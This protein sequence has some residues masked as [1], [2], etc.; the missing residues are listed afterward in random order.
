[1]I[2]RSSSVIIKRI[3]AAQTRKGGKAAM[4]AAPGQVQ[5]SESVHK[6][7]TYNGV[8]WHRGAISKRFDGKEEPGK[9]SSMV[10]RSFINVHGFRSISFSRIHLQRMPQK[11]Q[12]LLPWLPCSRH[13]VHSGR[14]RRKKCPSWYHPCGFLHVVL[15]L[16][17]MHFIVF[18]LHS[19]ALDR[20]PRISNNPR[21]G[22]SGRGGKPY[23]PSV[24]V[25]DK[26]LPTS[27]V[28]Y[29][30]GQKGRSPCHRHTE[31]CLKPVAIKDTGSKTAQRTVIANTTTGLALNEQPVSQGAC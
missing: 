9:S 19:L 7:A 10:S 6:G 17:L 13:K 15:S 4:F 16:F 28:C 29:R 1:M 24:H 3:P 5:L 18:S 12:K 20:A 30:C 14:K 2:P 25:M 26:P 27:Y 23:S 22:G 31:I 8:T 21:G 11:A